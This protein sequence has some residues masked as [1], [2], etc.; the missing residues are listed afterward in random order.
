ME[1]LVDLI[2]YTFR[3]H[4]EGATKPSKAVRKWDG[5]TPYAVHPVWC[6]MTLLTETT[7]PEDLRH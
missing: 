6:A 1:K 2:A 5:R 4:G 3:A 7:L